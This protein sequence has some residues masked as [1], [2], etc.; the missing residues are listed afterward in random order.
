M[1]AQV[2]L[3]R[4]AGIAVGLYY[5]W[6]IIAV[7]ITLSLASFT[8]Q[9]T[10]SGRSAWIRSTISLKECLYSGTNLLSGKRPTRERNS[11]GK[12]IGRRMKNESYKPF[13]LNVQKPSK[14]L[15]YFVAKTVNRFLIDCFSYPEGNRKRLENSKTFQ[16]ASMQGFYTEENWKKAHCWC[17]LGGPENAQ[18]RQI[19]QGQMPDVWIGGYEEA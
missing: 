1:R 5:S 12:L 15:L 4:I 19:W 11:R 14:L 6:I 2:K 9:R 3:G 10:P 8:E 16:I 13:I 18:G 17:E 7:L